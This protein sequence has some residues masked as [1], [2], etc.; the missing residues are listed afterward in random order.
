M[1]TV[2]LFTIVVLVASTALAQTKEILPPPKPAVEGPSLDAT[3]GFIQ[4]HL[5]EQG[6][7]STTETS[8][9]SFTQ[10]TFEVSEAT[11]DAAS[12]KL[13]YRVAETANTVAPAAAAVFRDRGAKSNKPANGN[14]AS[15]VRVEFSFRD[16]GRLEVNTFTDYRNNASAALKEAMGRL[17]GST[18]AG[19][20]SD[21]PDD[22]HITTE[23]YFLSAFLSAG[24]KATVRSA[25][26]DNS[27]SEADVTPGLVFHDEDMAKRVA[28]AMVHAVELCGVSKEK[29]PF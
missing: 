18:S 15:D 16:V 20:T 8:A 4:K 12:C 6:K 2:T 22:T 29:E 1:Q 13:S 9:G 25:S 19:S 26:P 7:I 27:S 14:R 21:S 3:M 28:K 17:F 24:K 10:F 5:N 11:T 23:V